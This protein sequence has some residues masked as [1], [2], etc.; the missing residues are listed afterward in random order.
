MVAD[1]RGDRI[2]DQV[3]EG[4]AG[5]GTLAPWYLASSAAKRSNSSCREESGRLWSEAQ[6]PSCEA[7][8]RVAK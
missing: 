2:G 5:R 1:I 4:A 7:R 8:G 3:P 6:A